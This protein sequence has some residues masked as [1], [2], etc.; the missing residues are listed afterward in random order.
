M[1][2]SVFQPSPKVQSF[3]P[4]SPEQGKGKHV[5]YGLREAYGIP[6]LRMYVEVTRCPGNS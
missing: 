1:L 3:C 5:S 6:L 2:T 4:P